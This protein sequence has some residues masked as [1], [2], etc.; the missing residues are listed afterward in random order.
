LNIAVETLLLTCPIC[1]TLF[2]K[3]SVG[4]PAH[5]KWTCS[6]R[7]RD[8]L[9][10]TKAEDLARLKSL[11]EKDSLLKQERERLEVSS[12]ADLDLDFDF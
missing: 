3:A 5:E 9:V 2:D 1:Y 12:A 6:E 10:Q 8:S 7:C 4:I 11:V